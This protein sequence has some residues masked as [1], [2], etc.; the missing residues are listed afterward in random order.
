MPTSVEEKVLAMKFD[1]RQFQAG[2]QQSLD[3]LNKLNN[4]LKLQEGTKG[5][6]GIG[7]AA[8][9]Q[10][11]S[12]KHVEAGAQGISD[13]LKNIGS[14]ASSQTGGL[15]TMANGV[16]HISDR[17]K[18]MGIVGM[19]A[20]SNVTNQAMFAGQNM[21]K[22]LTL[23]PVNQGF[24]EYETNMNSIQTILGNTQAA[25]EKL[26]PEQHLGRV[27]GALDELNHYSDQTIY[28]FAEMAKN[29]GT[30]TAAGVGLDE[31]TSSIKGIANLAALS[32]SNSEQ[33]SAAMY[34]LS[35]AIS[36]GKVSLEDWNSV[37]NAGMGG[38]VFKRALAENAV[39]MGTL[40]K[41]AL[42][43]EGPMKNVTISGKSFRE[44][45]TAKPGQESWLT[46]KVLT[47]TLSQFTGDLDAA[48]LKAQGFTDAQI[49]GIMKQAEMAKNAA[50]EVKTFSQLMGTLKE[51]A[52]SGW[53]QTWK[54]V[55]GDFEE[56]K[57]LFTNVNNVLGGMISKSADARNAMLKEWDD[58]GGR[59]A[60]IEGLGNA[61]KAL[62][63]V[64]KPIG[65][66]FREIFPKT[67][68]VELANMSKNFAAFTKN[69]I[70]G[71]EAMENLKRTA[72]GFFALLDIGWMIIKQVVSTIFD[73]LGVATEG[74]GGILKFTGNIGDFIVKVR[75]AI[76]K[77][78]GLK[79]IFKAIGGVLA[80]PIQ[81][82]KTFIGFLGK[83]VN[84]VAGMEIFNDLSPL[85]D[86]G[87][88]IAKAWN[89][90]RDAFGGV[91]EASGGFLDKMGDF[92][93][94]LGSRFAEF[95]STIGWGD[96]FGAVGTGLI[97]V[98]TQA[99][100]SLLGG[101][102]ISGIIQDI[103]D[104][105]SALTGSLEA[106]QQM[107]KATTL[108]Q[109]AA[110][111]LVLAIAMDKIS[112][113]DAEKIAASGA[114]I[115][116]LMAD[117]VGAMIALDKF[118]TAGSYTQLP[119]IAGTMILVAVAINIL[120]NAMT[121]MAELD[122]NGI[123]KGLVAVTALMAAL[124]LSMKYMPNE[125]DMIKSGAAVILLALGIK[126]LASAL[127][128][129][130]GL[131]WEDMTKGL[132]GV[133]AVLAA[134]GF[135]LK[136]GKI[137]EMSLKQGAGL[138][139]LSFG[140]SILAKAIASM[141]KQKGA[142][143]A[144][145]L[146]AMS[147]ALVAI[148]GALKM[149]PKDT[150]FAAAAILVVSL[151]LGNIAKA[152]AQFAD[153]DKGD[154]AGS[155]IMLAVSLNLIS[156]SMN[157]M[158]NALPGAVALLVVAGAL[159]VLL[160]TLQAF[161][162]MNI[163]DI[164][165]A[166]G[167]L[168]GVFIII[169]VA[170]LL[171]APVVPA[172]LAL[173]IAV[174]ALGLGMML[175]GAAIF[176]FATG[177]TLLSTLGAGAALAIGALVGALLDQVPKLSQKLAEALIALAG[178]VTQAAP[179]FGN[180]MLAVLNTFIDVIAKLTPKVVDVLLRLLT[181][182]LDKLAEY[183]PRMVDS[184]MRLIT[185]I[186]NGI[187]K[188]VKKM[189]SAATKVITEFLGALGDNIPKIADA[190]A[191]MVIKLVNGIADAIR[192]NSKAMGEAGANLGKAIIEGMA[193]ALRGGWG[194]ITD[195]AKG[196]AKAAL[197][198]AK[199]FLGI[200]S[201]SKE[202][203]KIGKFVV[204]GFRKGIDGNKD[205]IYAAFSD[206]KKMLKDFNKEAE[207]DIL[208]LQKKLKDQ[209]KKGASKKEQAKTKKALA[210]AKKEEKASQRAYDYVSK[211]L[212]NETTALGKLA[213]KYDQVTAKIEA[214]KKT[215]EDAIKTRDDYKNSIT[216]QYGDIATPTGETKLEDYMAGLK[217]QLE[218][219]KTFT[220]DIQRL[221]A[222]GL[223]DESYKDLL[224]AGPEALPFIKELLGGG[225]GAVD[226][227]NKINK[228]LDSVAGSLGKGA[229]SALYQAAVD[230]AAG[231]V[232]GLEK[233]Q[234]AIEAQMDKI[235]DAMVKAIKKKLGI[236]S[237]SRVFAEV[238]GYSGQGLAKGL[239]NT[240][241][242][243]TK[244]AETLGM[245]ATEALRKSMSN[246][247]KMSLST[248]DMTP[249][250]RPKLDLTDVQKGAGKIGTLLPSSKL[251]L[252]SAYSVAAS[253]A[254]ALRARASEEDDDRASAGGGRPINFTQNNY[255]P[256]ALSNAEIYRQNKN[257]I[258]TAKGAL[259][260]NAKQSRG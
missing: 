180:A 34:Q 90:V 43:L 153:F 35:Q 2:I 11:A 200:N 254:A 205:Q 206:L 106:M 160:P 239:A 141:A 233:Q 215:L 25:F 176:L 185:G 129:M 93:G 252:S 48:T 186:L 222:L 217:K 69:L 191:K 96:V 152:L 204:Q 258:S 113:L 187:A 40:S 65:Q 189:A 218:D 220:N 224:A 76:K 73:L 68:G 98:I 94:N 32:G 9:A 144:E 171:L 45:I 105:F 125:T 33:A 166:L 214:A 24:K 39:A 192:K 209:K 201:P 240:A 64:I 235:A 165:A 70:P 87:D 55:F 104:A 122:W 236:K 74:S 208:S 31:A 128:D 157:A 260:T 95:V 181:M 145:G 149:M 46:S 259:A 231:L 133:G 42:K 59:K 22:S 162:A 142:D 120:A 75:D 83:L 6:Q 248:T 79:N 175:A 172:I 8:S 15:S 202:F 178:V 174:A 88:T 207:K 110:A 108:L 251:N 199:N 92:F 193:N 242:Q 117:L 58:K 257:L 72:K 183:V 221:R 91:G 256:K 137:E 5:L 132:I 49:K 123:A 155:L 47:Q 146:I 138:L 196:V 198:S 177:L 131:S 81:L 168:A 77:G 255:S 1:G 143:T 237:P 241:P 250:I 124:V 119:L 109:L 66:A 161:A 89:K 112:K 150:I 115:T 148:A 26:S 38:S 84:G 60:A 56:A 223:N 229:S 232:K 61:F 44:S 173:G 13:K 37:V 213:V 71:K 219:T 29:I 14:T 4:S 82:V 127:T 7:T 12:L 101:G 179:A 249:V 19:T 78:D 234:K 50:T 54:T 111:V 216:E 62:M 17:F 225:K 57:V 130:A 151:A 228:E 147:V 80:V 238:G 134:L 135:F 226:E 230:A 139:L 27:T 99:I 211:A 18:T 3:S 136:F 51:S 30:F 16:Q 184:G 53:S 158:M 102:G 52:G 247:D 86:L 100:H 63:G 212:A 170:G 114:A 253:A 85:A 194:V 190:G 126:V 163:G 116:V 197:D 23:E 21:I 103:K 243:V 140:I 28:N 203:I 167:V 245:Q 188:N 97:L 154:M 246:M 10:T 156:L 159:A 244:T 227:I 41:N 195:A 182:L 107:L 210:Q 20:I 164:A 121:K 36:S 169:G 118:M 67:T